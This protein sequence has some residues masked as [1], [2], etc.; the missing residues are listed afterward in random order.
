MGGGARST[1]RAIGGV[2]DESTIIVRPA[3]HDDLSLIA[4]IERASFGDPWSVESF[5]SVL[6]LSHI[7]FLVAQ[8]R[9]A[10][11]SLLGYVVAITLAG[12]GE[13]ANL[14][15]A[16]TARRHGIGGLLL[17]RIVEET[18]F[19]GVSALYLEVRESN[20]AAKGLYGKYGF[21]ALGVRKRYYQDNGENALVLWT[22]KI[23][24]E[25]FENIFNARVAE[26]GLEPVW[27]PH[28]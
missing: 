18:T 3:R 28:S 10:D 19:A 13:I 5:A 7:R 11:D 8:H 17:D 15:V 12:E 23:T 25:P 4:A 24:E 20:D 2:I 27:K 9:T 1:A 21:S 6:D 16:P 26:M 22:D 14:A